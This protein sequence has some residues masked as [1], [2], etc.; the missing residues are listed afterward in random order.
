MAATDVLMTARLRLEPFEERHLSDRYVG[1]LNDPEVVRYSEQRHVRH[2]LDSCRAFAQSFRDSAHLLWAIHYDAVEPSHV[3]NIAAYVDGANGV[4]D[5]TIVLGE[6]R[7]WGQGVGLEAW[8]A[9]CDYLLKRPSI[10]KVT[11][12]TLANNHAMLSIMRRSGMVE[13]GRRTAHYVIDGQPVDVV[14]AALFSVR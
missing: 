1:W 11:A 6:R 14:Y 9:V 12:G 4:A 10:R 5:V 3:G 2:T 8:A 7:V 13:D